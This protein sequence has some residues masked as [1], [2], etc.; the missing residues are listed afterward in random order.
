MKDEERSRGSGEDRS[1]GSCKAALEEQ[2]YAELSGLARRI[3]A[4]ERGDHT[5]QPTALVHEAWLRLDAGVANLDRDE[6][7]GLAARV[8]R[9]VLVDHARRRNANK[10]GGGRERLPLEVALSMT[11]LQAVDTLA[12]NEAL[13]GLRK[14][15]PELA[16]IAVL[17]LFGGYALEDI[18]R[19]RNSS[20]TS[21]HRSWELA[22]VL[23]Q[24]DLA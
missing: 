17:R 4:T 7:L 9:N 16:E 13:D 2:L 1:G 15:D 3:F 23:L 18:A 24:R 14:Q 22:R 11:S 19:L 10:R 12:L 20:T 6:Y 8:M 5:L 21:V